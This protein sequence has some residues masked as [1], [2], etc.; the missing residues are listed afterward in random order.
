VDLE[1]QVPRIGLQTERP[2]HHVEHVGEEH[3]LGLDR[4]GAGF[5]L[6]QIE[7]VAD[8]VEQVGAGG[9]DSFGELD[10]LV[11]QVAFRIV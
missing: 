11:R 2:R 5:D 4:D 9:M 6:R 3:V 10:L 1:R 7:N 8:Q